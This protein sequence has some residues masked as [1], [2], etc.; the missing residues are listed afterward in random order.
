[1]SVATNQNAQAGE[2]GQLDYSHLPPA[3][4]KQMEA[5]AR[6]AAE[7]AG[8]AQPQPAQPQPAA[9]AQ[10]QPAQPQP[11]E[12]AAPAAPQ[13]ENWEHKYRSVEG[14][15][16]ALTARVNSLQGENVELKNDVAFLSE[17]LVE[18]EEERDRLLARQGSVG[19]LTAADVE[20]YGEDLVAAM[21]RAATEAAAPL[22][23][24]VKKLREENRG[25]KAGV[26]TATKVTA[27]QRQ[28]EFSRVLYSAVPDFDALNAAGSDFNTW[29]RE[30]QEVSGQLYLEGIRN[31][32][33][34]L[35]AQAV[36]RYVEAYKRTKAPAQ[37]QPQPATPAAPA[38]ARV[39][40]ESFAAPAPSRQSSPAGVEDEY[41]PE[42]QIRSFA[43]E[44]SKGKWRGREQEVSRLQAL[45]QKAYAEGKVLYGR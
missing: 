15:I 37:S 4:R 30:T 32:A 5:E 25:L 16:N 17:K 27:E 38:Q 13:G 7:A 35:D 34:A 6:R 41:I 28:D 12:P 20:T 43:L 24:E 2:S 33:K 42:S 3:V 39:P 9:E 18:A 23:A 22:E 44:V 45:H 8:P 29:L 21:R 19:S 11:A 36:I 10:P 1:M 26:E 40:L 14:R 31:A